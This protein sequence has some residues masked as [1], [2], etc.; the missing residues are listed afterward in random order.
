M[1]EIK[2]QI[3]YEFADNCFDLLRL[4]SA[5]YVMTL[6]IMR[7]VR[8]QEVSHIFD[9]WNGVVVLFCI[10]GFL[11]PASMERSKNIWEFL[12]KRVIRIVPSMWVCIIIGIVVAA[13]FCGFMADKTF[14]TWFAGQLFFVRD[15]PQP[16]FISNFGIGN[17]QANLWTMIFT[18]QFYL[19]TALIYKIMKDRK[20][21]VWITVLGM[22][23]ALN[24]AVPYVQQVLPASWKSIVSHSCLPYFYIYFAGWFIYR[25]REKIVPVLAKTKIL[26]I[27]LFIMRALY[28]EKHGV[29]IGEYQDM[30]QI[31]L[32]CMLTIG[33]GYSF[34]KIR[35]KIDLS[36]GLYLYHMVIV[37]IF[38]QIGLVGNMM[39]AV[40]VYAIALLCA[41]AS[42]YLVDDT[43]A[44]IFKRAGSGKYKEL[45]SD[46][47]SEIPA[48][49][50]VT[51][52]DEILRTV[53]VSNE[54]ETD[55]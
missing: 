54:D 5:F 53:S 26:C 37:D 18:V 29:R 4:Y 11:V 45:E 51:A 28:C 13:L 3:K 40:A 34:G 43:V 33:F 38:V 20:L 8:G 42:Y 32:L 23:M 14:V 47:V 46:I 44:K 6:H 10:S 16:D 25:Y 12:K 17:F 35:F 31:L 19:I 2:K 9:W 24:L 41:F 22:S 7:H 55:F 52:E 27:L 21:W 50:D 36:Y 15:L 30:I 48:V 39:Y 49:P 1:G